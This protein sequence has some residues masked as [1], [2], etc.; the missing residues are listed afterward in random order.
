MK[1]RK[2]AQKAPTF[3]TSVGRTL[4]RS[5]KKARQTARAHGTPVYVWID[6]KIVAEKP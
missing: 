5:A 4:R 6:G 3:A 2:Q 1:P